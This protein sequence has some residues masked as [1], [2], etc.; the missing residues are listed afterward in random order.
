[1]VCLHGGCLVGLHEGYLVGLHGGYFVVQPNR[2]VMEP[3]KQIKRIVKQRKWEKRSLNLVLVDTLA[4][5]SPE[6]EDPG[7][8]AGRRQAFG[9]VQLQGGALEQVLLQ[10]RLVLLLDCLWVAHFDVATFKPREDNL[11]L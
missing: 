4:H 7:I 6:S 1:M 11:M 10:L 3:K 8:H 9:A 2:I 5:L